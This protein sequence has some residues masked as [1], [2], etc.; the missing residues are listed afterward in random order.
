M[1]DRWGVRRVAEL[2]FVPFAFGYPTNI[3]RLVPQPLGIRLELIG[4]DQALGLMFHRS[5][6]RLNARAFGN[7][8][9]PEWVQLDCG[10]LPSAFVGWARRA[11]DLPRDLHDALAPDA[12]PED[13]VPVSEALA[14]PTAE[15]GTWASVSLASVWRGTRLGLATKALA[16][17][18]YGARRTVGVCQYDSP[19]LR[20]HTALGPLRIIDP[21]VEYHS[22]PHKTFIYALDD[23]PR[24]LDG[25][26]P[27]VDGES[28]SFSTDALHE[29]LPYTEQFGSGLGHLWIVPP[30]LVK[31]RVQ[32]QW[33]KSQTHLRGEP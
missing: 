18:A 9:M 31:G 16:L 11:R 21:R 28:V 17:A 10:V 26:F 15:P 5:L 2:G 7:M 23:V 8:G 4:S 12:S 13:L 32:C 24:L 19:A 6:N 22:K 25:Q 3:V 1:L 30:G 27:S 33:V 14:I 20:V 29:L